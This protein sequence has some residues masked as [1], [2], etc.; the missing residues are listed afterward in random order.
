MLARSPY[1]PTFIR[2]AIVGTSARRSSNR[3]DGVAQSSPITATRGPS[4]MPFVPSRDGSTADGGRADARGS[5]PR[6]A[7]P[8]SHFGPGRP[9]TEGLEMAILRRALLAFAAV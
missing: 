9:G 1:I 3:R 7:Y 8:T 2:C 4:C 6:L 5:H